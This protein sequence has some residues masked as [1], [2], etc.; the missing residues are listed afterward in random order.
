MI[1]SQ[2]VTITSDNLLNADVA[3]DY[4]RTVPQADIIDWLGDPRETICP[5]RVDPP[6]EDDKTKV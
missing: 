5:V 2:P 4:A 1:D 6:S 3:P